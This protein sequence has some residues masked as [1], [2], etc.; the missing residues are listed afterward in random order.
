MSLCTLMT[1]QELGRII[2]DFSELERQEIG[3]SHNHFRTDVSYRRYF[4][5]WIPEQELGGICKESYRDRMLWRATIAFVLKGY[6]IK[7]KLTKNNNCLISRKKISMKIK[8]FSRSIFIYISETKLGNGSFCT[9]QPL[10]PQTKSRKSLF[11]HLQLGS[12][13]PHRQVRMIVFPF[14]FHY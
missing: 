9:L 7:T 6:S 1:E 11:Y 10:S 13:I 8:K 4:Y 3:E 5:I 2:K 12:A 14:I